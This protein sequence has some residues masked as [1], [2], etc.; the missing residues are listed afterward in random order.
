LDKPA[1]P[2]ALFP[3]PVQRSHAFVGGGMAAKHFGDD[4][5]GFALRLKPKKI[6]Q[7][8]WINVGCHQVMPSNRVRLAFRARE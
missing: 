3:E 6:G 1:F 8:A 2:F 5:G 4:G 7:P